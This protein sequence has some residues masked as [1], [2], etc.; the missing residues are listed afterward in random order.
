MEKPTLSIIIPAYNVEKY[1][2]Q[3]IEDLQSQ[4]FIDWE[5][6][7]V[8]DCSSDATVETV[9]R[10]TAGDSRF[11]LI[12]RDRN[13]G[14]AFIPRYEAAAM[15]TSEY[16]IALDADDRINK[17]YLEKLYGRCLETGADIVFSMNINER[18]GSHDAIFNHSVLDTDEVYDGDKLVIHTLYGWKFAAGGGL[19]RRKLY[20][21]TINE[22]IRIEKEDSLGK[23]SLPLIKNPFLDEVVTRMLLINAS[24]VAFAKEAEYIYVYN[25]GSVMATTIYMKLET[26]LM[27]G[28]IIADRFG[29]ESDEWKRFLKAYFCYVVDMMKIFTPYRKNPPMAITMLRNAYD[30]KLWKEAKDE[31]SKKYYAALSSGYLPAR[32]IFSLFPTPPLG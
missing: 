19:Y 20:V 6:V 21:D 10:A 24:K 22:A 23:L 3:L 13:S 11:R 9:E 16:V 1:I 17:E 25:P 14:G 32:I 27:L 28:K 18:V 15:A 26:D 31:I 12:R 2:G 8:D 30:R 7:I 5:A 29:K 4:T